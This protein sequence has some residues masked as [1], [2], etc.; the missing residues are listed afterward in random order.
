M[1]Q[2]SSRHGTHTPV[3]G[4]EKIHHTLE[5]TGIKNFLKQLLLLL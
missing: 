3:A 1:G 4:H 2:L 5:Q